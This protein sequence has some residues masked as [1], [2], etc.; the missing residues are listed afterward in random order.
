MG[1]LLTYLPTPRSRVL[2]EKLTGSQLVKKFPAFLE[3]EGSS[4]YSQV[5]ATCPYP[6]PHQSIPFS[7]PDFL[8]IHLNIIPPP[9]S[10]SSKWSLFPQVSPPKRCIH[11]SSPPYVLPPPNSL[12]IGLTNY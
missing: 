3:P 11:L 6:E 12:P 10:R 4:P 8:K 9:T 5:P 1:P 7:P 2:L